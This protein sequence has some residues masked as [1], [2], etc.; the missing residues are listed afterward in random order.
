MHMRNSTNLT[1][2]QVCHTRAATSQRYRNK[3]E[4]TQRNDILLTL[5]SCQKLWRPEDLRTSSLKSC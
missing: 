5:T 1:H 3:I 4:I 2:A